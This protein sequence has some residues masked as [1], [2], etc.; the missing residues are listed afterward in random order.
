MCEMLVEMTELHT[1]KTGRG[2]LVTLT[3]LMAAAPMVN[4]AM[5]AASPVLVGERIVSATL[6]AVIPTVTFTLAAV[7]GRLAGPLTDRL[8]IALQL[9]VLFG[10][11]AA[12][13]IL[14]ATGATFTSFLVAGVL[15]APAQALCNSATNRSIRAVAPASDVPRWTGVKQSGVQVGQLVAAI[16][17]VTAVSSGVGWRIG[18]LA[19]ALVV[20]VAAFGQMPNS[21]SVRGGPTVVARAPRTPLPA[22]ARL[23]VVVV[24]L[25]GLAM[26]S[27][28]V[29]L[30]LFVS[31]ALQLGSV[32]GGAAVAC[33]GLSGV[34]SRTVIA[35][36]LAR[37][38]STAAA[39]RTTTASALLVPIGLWAAG[40]SAAW[41]VWLVAVIAGVSLLGVS[42]VANTL[43]IR[44]CPPTTLGAASGQLSM[45]MYAGFAVGPLATG[46]LLGWSGSFAVAW[47]PSALSIAAAVVLTLRV[48]ADKRGQ[49]AV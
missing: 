14:A 8:P 29:Y 37:G 45:W 32:A 28:N 35:R 4:Y 39:M 47:L 18:F 26:Q 1:E 25:T 12:S 38:W 7:I 41:T 27:V 48:P 5:S 34:A 3:A 16:V 44:S 36:A 40:T 19:L 46:A 49:S 21:L 9:R 22:A 6:L 43:L 24:G 31:D 42:T 20:L 10:L 33:V 17:V 23:A 2:I 11:S 30:A 15:A 13:L